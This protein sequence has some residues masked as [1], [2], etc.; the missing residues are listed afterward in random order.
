MAVFNALTQIVDATTGNEIR[1]TEVGQ[2]YAILV[3]IYNQTMNKPT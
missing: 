1:S 3:I 2:K